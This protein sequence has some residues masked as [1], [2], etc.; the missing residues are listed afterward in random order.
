M[1]CSISSI[2]FR[3]GNSSDEA[4]LVEAMPGAVRKHVAG[5]EAK[6][7]LAKDTPA[8]AVDELDIS[9]DMVPTELTPTM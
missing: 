9:A 7:D 3:T 6:P 5:M 4:D 8:A 1:P 2:C